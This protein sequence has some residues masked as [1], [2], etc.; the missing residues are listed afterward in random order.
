MKGDHGSRQAM[1]R[2]NSKLKTGA[3]RPVLA[4]NQHRH[5]R[6]II[7]QLKHILEKNKT[8]VLKG[9]DPITW[10]SFIY[11]HCFGGTLTDFIFP[12]Y[13]M[14]AAPWMCVL[15]GHHLYSLVLLVLRFEVYLGFLTGQ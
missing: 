7:T 14:T 8:C 3:C 5:S 10:S 15:L 13:S 9:S 12:P 1:I 2:D 4:F 11:V 6:H